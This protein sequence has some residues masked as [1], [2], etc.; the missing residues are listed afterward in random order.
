MAE[1]FAAVDSPH[2]IVRPVEL[3]KPRL[4]HSTPV[5]LPSLQVA[6]ESFGVVGAFSDG[7]FMMLPNRAVKID[8][9][10]KA[11]FDVE[12]FVDGLLVR[13]LSDTF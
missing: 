9:E 6:V 3:R 11:P 7:A 1:A 2:M 13:S 8:F 12:K 10:A 5:L 4:E